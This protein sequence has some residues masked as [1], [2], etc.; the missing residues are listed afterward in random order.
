MYNN[1]DTQFTA[2]QMDVCDV[3]YVFIFFLSFGI[4]RIRLCVINKKKIHASNLL[5]TKSKLIISF[6]TLLHPFFGTFL[7]Q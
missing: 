5:R 1:I 6:L 7:L 2:T 4:T 3:S